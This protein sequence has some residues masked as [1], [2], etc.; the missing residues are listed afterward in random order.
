MDASLLQAGHF[1]PDEDILATISEQ[2]MNK[3][4]HNRYEIGPG[5]CGCIR[6][7]VI[8]PQLAVAQAL[9]VGFAAKPETA[10]K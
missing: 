7:V 6:L 4:E 3:R 1:W 2:D 8:E 10:R 9:A 5:R